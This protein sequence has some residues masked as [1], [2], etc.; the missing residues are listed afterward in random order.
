MGTLPNPLV[1]A[2]IKVIGYAA[3]GREAAKRSASDRS[4]LL[5]GAARVFAGWVVG[6]P[7]L[8]SLFLGT[9]VAPH[10]IYAALTI[11]RLL[12]WF[13]LILAWY[14]PNGGWR[15]ALSW[16]IAGTALSALIDFTFFALAEDFS[17]LRATWTWC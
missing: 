16:A 9:A 7:V 14:R 10:W 1:L 17:S 3:F 6:G 12:L 8:L 5:F 13:V 15:R 11:P 2:A 4:A